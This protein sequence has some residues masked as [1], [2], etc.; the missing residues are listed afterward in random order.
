MCGERYEKRKKAMS[1][2]R[3]KE[4]NFRKEMKGK[5]VDYEGRNEMLE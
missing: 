3:E 2:L 4:G 1:W 5:T